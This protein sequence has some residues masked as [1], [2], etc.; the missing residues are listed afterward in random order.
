MQLF[1]RM[2][3]GYYLIMSEIVDTRY[4]LQQYQ[5]FN[6]QDSSSAACNN[7][8]SSRSSTNA[9]VVILSLILNEIPPTRRGGVLTIE[10][11]RACVPHCLYLLTDSVP[12]PVTSCT[13]EEF[14]C[15][16]NHFAQA[17]PNPINSLHTINTKYFVT[18]IK[19]P[20]KCPIP[21]T[22]R[23]GGEKQQNFVS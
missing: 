13:C 16:L 15:T 11:R 23:T 21:N 1:A 8:A 5:V 17:G 12:N 18:L 7:E 3:T 6:Y 4:F 14:M 10:W 9:E 19:C 20:I 22:L 2:G